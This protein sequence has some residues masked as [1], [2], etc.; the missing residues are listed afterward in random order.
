MFATKFL[1][2]KAMSLLAADTGTLAPAANAIYVA[3]VMNNIA[4]SETIVFADVTMATF[5]G[6]TELAVELNAQPEG[7]DPATTDSVIDLK[8]PVG[9]FRW[10]VTGLT[11]LPQ[12]IYGYVLLNHAKD[13]VWASQL[14][15]TP[16]TLNVVGDR[17]DLGDVS[18][19]LPANSIS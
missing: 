9:G 3:L 16:Q 1:R 5:D 13:T 19:T 11:N 18:L 10:A 8:A 6:S 12:T 17:I 15:E 4:P 7:F 14:L 2:N